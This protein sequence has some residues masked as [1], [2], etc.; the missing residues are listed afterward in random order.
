LPFHDRRFELEEIDHILSSPR[1][2]LVVVYGR[3]GVGKST[4][5]SEALAGQHH[6]FYQATTRALPQQLEDLTSALQAFAPDV[7]VAGAFPSF[8]AW[9][10]AISQLVRTRP[11]VLHVIVLDELPY[12]AETD[13]SVPTTLQRWWDGIRRA[14]TTNLKVFLLGSLVS[15]MEEYTL[16]ERGPLHNRRTGQL[17]LDPLNYADAALFYPGYSPADRVAAY[18]IWGGM[19]SYLESMQPEIDLWRNVRESILRPGT[20]LAEEPVW[21]RFADLRNDAIYA[22]ILRAIALGD[23]RMSRIALTVGKS[24]ADEIAFHLDRLVDLRVVQRI[25][26]IHQTRHPRSRQALYV[27]A[28]HYVAFWYRFVDRLRHVLALRRYDD[29]LQRIQVEFDQYVSARAYEDVCRQFVW[30]SLAADRLPIDE[31]FDE[32]GSW[33]GGREEF[34]DEIDVVAAR[35]GRAVLVGECK[36]SVQPVGMR[37]LDGLVFA[38]RKAKADLTPIDRPWFALF[39]RSGFTAELGEEAADPD[40]RILLF[41]PEDLYW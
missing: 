37:E 38:L 32:V 26:P 22:S 1:P 10:N 2:E 31:A 16:S 27:L 7:V 25:V 17:R 13:P 18:A 23:H 35:D 14:N 4:L 29:A 12:L 36:W 40:R 21:L 33:W 11:H 24:R 20:R 30:Q 5:L 19:P 3:R 28:D 34:Q 9:L 6:L 8:D 41:A 15:W 39:S